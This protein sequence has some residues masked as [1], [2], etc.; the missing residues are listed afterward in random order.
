MSEKD[1]ENVKLL[2]DY[3][4]EEYSHAR[5]SEKSYR[6]LKEKYT[7]KLSKLQG[8]DE[9][10]NVTNETEDINEPEEHAENIFAHIE[11]HKSKGLFGGMLK[12]KDSGDKKE[13]KKDSDEKKDDKK[14]EKKPPNDKKEEK[15]DSGDE[16]EDKPL[17][18]GESGK[19]E[20][21][22]PFMI[23]P[24]GA[25]MYGAGTDEDPYRTTPEK[26]SQDAQQEE[27]NIGDESSSEP[28]EVT[29]PSESGAGQPIAAPQI[30]AASK[31][32]VEKIKVMLDGVKDSKKATD[33]TVQNLYESVGEM[34]SMLFQSDASLKEM[35]ARVEKF[36]DNVKELRPERLV[37][38]FKETDAK[39][40]ATNLNVEKTQ[41]K[42]EDISEKTNRIYELIKSIG[43]V[44]NL[45]N[46]DKKLQTKLNDIKEAV[47]YIERLGSKTE[48]IFIDL[49]KGLDDL[50]LYKAKQEGI[51][52]TMKDVLR[53]L[54]V[55][56]ANMQGF[57]TKKDIESVKKG[58]IVMQKQIEDIKKEFS[59]LITIKI[60]D[61]IEALRK[62]R[63]DIVFFMDSIR[64]QK[65]RKKIKPSE[66]EM[67]KI[68]NEEKLR[69]ID[70]RLETEW[71]KFSKMYEAGNVPPPTEKSTENNEPVKEEGTQE[72][73][74]ETKEEPE[75][76]EPPKE[77]TPAEEEP[78]K[79]APVEEKPEESTPK[80][81]KTKSVKE[82]VDE[83]VSEKSNDSHPT[84][85]EKSYVEEMSKPLKAD[86]KHK[87]KP[88]KPK[89]E[90]TSKVAET[91]EK[92][93]NKKKTEE[94]PII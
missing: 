76:N 49:N 74:A 21:G 68:K 64:D 71:R 35:D 10:E 44:E 50:V 62:E 7:E 52:D 24:G 13:E 15:K 46:L 94:K 60:P 1:I 75:V 78:K 65:R 17:Q 19:D 90:Q 2:L 9:I 85:N 81:E 6:E 92:I 55:F 51:D 22:V 40:E 30:D 12:K 53:T 39:F 58:T 29:L 56:K 27:V 43:G 79:E 31:V 69:K 4:E 89:E 34:R 26:Q 32:E 72:A 66:Y 14:E 42:L 86:K 38:K 18:E 45:V 23:G 91:L 77:E 88:K 80:K 48:K 8:N 70:K 36:T 83:V 93:E 20:N 41:K 82:V 73:P 25:K 57:V 87:K 54:D 33:E 47:R 61:Q 28:E 59:P 16:K 3:L 11:D 67:M 37:K 5:I 63:E 84:N